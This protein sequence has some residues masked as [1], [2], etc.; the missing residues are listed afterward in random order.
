M[1]QIKG[2]NYYRNLKPYLYLIVIIAIFS[3]CA[4]LDVSRIQYN[5]EKQVYEYPLPGLAPATLRTNSGEL[6][7]EDNFEQF[8]TEMGEM[9]FNYPFDERMELANSPK[10]SDY[11]I[12]GLYSESVHHI[13]EGNYTKAA[14][15]LGI[16]TPDFSDEEENYKIVSADKLKIMLDYKFKYPDPLKMF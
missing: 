5:P 1:L 11:R 9:N 2:M 13:K 4:R 10:Q 3:G 8:I 16:E 15:K 14:E 6:V 12:A 7:T